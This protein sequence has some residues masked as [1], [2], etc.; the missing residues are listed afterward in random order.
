M[1]IRWAKVTL[2]IVV[3]IGIVGPTVTSQAAG[4][5]P[6]SAADQMRTLLFNAQKQVLAEKTESPQ[7]VSQ[8]EQLYQDDLRAD[9]AAA[10][11]NV[12]TTLDKAFSDAQTAAVS[13]SALSLAAMR[14]WLWSNLL[15]GSAQVVLKALEKGD[16][17]TAQRWLML[18]EFRKPTKFARPGADATLAIAGV[19]QGTKTTSDAV[20]AVRIDFLDT[21]QAKLDESLA[22]ADKA[23]QNKFDVRLAEESGLAAGYFAILADTYGTQRGT[24]AAQAATMHFTTLVN[25]A[26][27]NDL[28]DFSTGYAAVTADLKHF[29]AAPLSEA[30]QARRAGQLMRYLALV[31]VEYGRGVQGGKVIHDIE[32]QEARTFY[33]GALAAFADLELT[34]SARD[35]T[36][37]AQVDT[38]LKQIEGQI[39]NVVEPSVLEG[40]VTEITNHLTSMIPQQWITLNSSADFDV[41]N[42]VL[43]QVVQAVQAGQYNLAES[44]RIEAYAL[45]DSGVE[46][47]LRGFAPDL[48]LKVEAMFWQGDQ[49]Q[50]GLSTL[51]ANKAKLAEVKAGVAALRSALSE[52]QTVLDN[53]KTAPEAVIGNAAIIVF[54]EGLEAVVILASLLASLRSAEQK[55]W[56]RSI[57]IG[58]ALSLLATAL[59]WA[60]AN[61]IIRQLAQFGEKLEAVLSIVAIAVLLLITNWFFHKTYWTGWMAELHSRKAQFL[62]GS[63]VIGP[64]L[65]LV[66]LGFTSIYREGFETVLFLQ[67]LVLDAGMRIVLEGVGLGMIGVAVVGFLVFNL[68]MRLPYKSMLVVTGV[69]IGVVLLTM[70]GNT[71]HVLQAVGWLPITPINGLYLP[72]WMG[73]W[74]GFFA[75]WQGVIAQI[76][77]AVFVVGSYVLAERMQASERSQKSARKQ[78]QATIRA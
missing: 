7:L 24:P 56:R 72:Y 21:Y 48:A 58:A 77:S 61:S 13:K 5:D 76:A 66:I 65:G 54:R 78:K 25:A 62:G 8:A 74:F 53:T 30:E 73:R 37:T 71:V 19:Q 31:P 47:K 36:K 38:Q 49:E 32:I 27:T 59:T 64:S 26:A 11:P 16:N 10:A 29:R 70:V 22:D 6:W 9:I 34:L 35:A 42:N 23:H 17:A 3:M 68:Q 40:N 14:G 55:Q 39:T 67:S 20:T 12:A 45:L 75:T 1:L 69:L 57:I 51:I 50:V 33:E 44:A 2:L 41:I 28:I 52:A 4:L 43:D 60:V 15:N 63:V 46:Q 18:R